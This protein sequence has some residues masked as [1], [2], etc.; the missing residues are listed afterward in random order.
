MLEGDQLSRY[1]NDVHRR[2]CWIYPPPSLA[3]IQSY[4]DWT[5]TTS[6]SSQSRNHPLG[7]QAVRWAQRWN[8]V[9]E[10]RRLVGLPQDRQK[11]PYSKKQLDEAIRNGAADPT[12][13]YWM[14]PPDPV[15]PSLLV[16]A[17]PGSPTQDQSARAGS[18]H[19][20][21]KQSSATTSS[22][23]SIDST[24][25]QVHQVSS[26]PLREGSGLGLAAYGS[27]FEAPQPAFSATPSTQRV[28]TGAFR[29]GAAPDAMLS[30]PRGRRP[31]SNAQFL[32]DPF[33]S[34]S[35]R[36][37]KGGRKH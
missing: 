16:A 27:T 10:L 34:N 36:S 35:D 14:D 28:Q 2:Q 33:S 4:K 25:K 17:R 37:Q 26:T 6:R 18:E 31:A 5:E 1:V 32:D 19:K 21:S 22:G 15:H 3:Q 8:D 20:S 11:N 29:E 13:D 23:S 9:N 12:S 30:C 7:P 24:G